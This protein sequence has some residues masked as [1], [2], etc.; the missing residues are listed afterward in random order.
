M[1]YRVHD[2]GKLLSYGRDRAWIISLY[3]PNK[4]R[5][6]IGTLARLTLLGIDACSVLMQKMRANDT[7]LFRDAGQ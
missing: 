2:R 3:Q 6:A 7:R 4:G 5:R 1:N